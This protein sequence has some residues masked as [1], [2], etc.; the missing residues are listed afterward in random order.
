MW[1]IN[2]Q[3]ITIWL[4]IGCGVRI[5]LTMPRRNSDFD[6]S[7]CTSEGSIDSTTESRC[8]SEPS[9]LER[10]PFRVPINWTPSDLGAK[11]RIKESTSTSETYESVDSN[12]V[13][14]GIR[15][16]ILK[17]IEECRKIQQARI[18]KQKK[19]K[20]KKTLRESERGS[21]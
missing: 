9:N 15:N 20:K 1:D 12:D 2:D 3:E 14:E 19:K 11:V 10:Y 21:G 16:F 4:R 7:H 6:T 17:E 13:N 18:E 5:A 8:R